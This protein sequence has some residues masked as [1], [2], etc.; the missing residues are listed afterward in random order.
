LT[1]GQDLPGILERQPEDRAHDARRDVA[2]ELDHRVG[3]AAL[4]HRVDRLARERAH[5]SARARRP[6]PA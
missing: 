1:Q 2:A 5:A 6:R 4:A 3:A